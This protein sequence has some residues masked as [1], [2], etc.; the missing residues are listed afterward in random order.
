MRNFTLT[1]FAMILMHHTHANSSGKNQDG[2]AIVRSDTIYGKIE[3]NFSTGAILVRQDTL[4]HIFLSGV[5]QV[6]ILNEHRDTFVPYRKNEKTMFYK[7]LV[8]GEHPLLEGAE[9]F[10]SIVDQNLVVVQEQEDL[11][12]LFGKKN[13]KDYIFI[14]NVDMYARN[15]LMDLFDFFNK[16]DSF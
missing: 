5:K 11:Y 8:D 3:I 2:Y 10:Y 6:T 7:L 13:I 15:E 12:D 4:N 16:N 14:R 1:L 9:T